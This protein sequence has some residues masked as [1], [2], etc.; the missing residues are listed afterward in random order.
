MIQAIRRRGHFGLRS[1]RV[2]LLAVLALCSGE[3]LAA[4][5]GD[6][7]A[8]GFQGDGVCQF[9]LHGYTLSPQSEASINQAVQK[10]IEQHRLAFG[11]ALRPDFRLRMRVY[12]RFEDFTNSPA[13]RRMTSL[14]GVY[15]MATREIVTWRQEMPGFLG[16]TLLHEASHAILHAHCRRA[17]LWL[18]EGA[19]DYFALSLYSGNDLNNQVLRRRWALLNFWLREGQ[20]PP[21]TPLLNATDQ[22]HWEKKGQE[23]AYAMSWSVF[24]FLMSSDS[25]KQLMRT[26]IREW[27]EPGRHEPVSS[28]QIGRLYP[29]GMTG[30]E[31]AWRRWIDPSG[32]AQSY[33]TPFTGTG[34]CR[35]AVRGATLTPSVQSSFDQGV[36]RLYEAHCALFD[37][38]RDPDFHLRVRL[39]G[40]FDD[41][42]RFTTNWMVSGYEVKP[43]ELAGVDGYYS[44]LCREIVLLDR[45]SPEKLKHGL[46]E[47]ANT[48]LLR[49]Q[50]ENLPH[51]VRVGSYPHFL[52]VAQPGSNRRQ[53]LAAAWLEAGFGPA[54]PPQVVSLMDQSAHLRADANADGAGQ[55]ATACWAMFEFL[56]I[57]EQNRQVLRTLLRNLQGVPGGGSESAAQ[58][59]RLYP[60]GWVRFESDF[61]EWTD[62]LGRRS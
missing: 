46:L 38:R 42:A 23:Q 52:A 39:F 15:L 5:A 47:L 19:A 25:N 55:T 24:Q 40:E 3:G 60:G 32:A 57:S 21:L 59:G 33:R 4:G 8:S 48:A 28:E 31:T 30:F 11:F 44:P 50:F 61:R 29:G 62:G 51:W 53:A 6:G 58:I 9:A 14:Q 18:M 10:L 37:S 20:L 35:F 27:Q 49:Q 16:T 17:P 41:Y 13:M 54:R 7:R 56:T 26:L 43:N 2:G 34:L 36:R 12:G 45:G 22:P 1:S